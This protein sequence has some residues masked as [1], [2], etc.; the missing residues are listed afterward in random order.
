M[1]AAAYSLRLARWAVIV[2]EWRAGLSAGTVNGHEGAGTSFCMTMRVKHNCRQYRMPD[3]LD[4]P[5]YAETEALEA[6]RVERR[7]LSGRVE[8][9]TV[10]EG[11]GRLVFCAAGHNRVKVLSRILERTPQVLARGVKFK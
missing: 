11:S 6:L 3:V 1:V 2:A 5:S 4:K 8:D 10:F 7:G 9:T